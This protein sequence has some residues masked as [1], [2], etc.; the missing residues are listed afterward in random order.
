MCLMAVLFCFACR[1]DTFS[2]F[3]APKFHCAR[4][5][6]CCRNSLSPSFLID[7]YKSELAVLKR[8]GVK[9]PEKPLICVQPGQVCLVKNFWHLDPDFLRDV[10]ERERGLE[11]Q[12]R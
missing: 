4:V 8:H 5:V 1:C 7:V 2:S 11:S 6:H 10:A 12:P 9:M 3:K